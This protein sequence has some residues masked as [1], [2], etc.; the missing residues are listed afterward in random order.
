MAV[1][2][3]ALLRDAAA[4]ATNAMAI[5]A[6]GIPKNFSSESPIFYLPVATVSGS[7]TNL[8]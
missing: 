1:I 2:A 3:I 8:A 5:T 4:L 6:I 7:N